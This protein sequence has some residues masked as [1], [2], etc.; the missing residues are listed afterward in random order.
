MT[1]HP[2]QFTESQREQIAQLENFLRD[3]IIDE[4]DYESE[5]SK[6]KRG[7]NVG[8][9]TPRTPG[10]SD[11][12]HLLS[13]T[14]NKRNS[15]TPRHLHELS[16][17]TDFTTMSEEALLL[18][19]RDKK[20]TSTHRLSL[21]RGAVDDEQQQ[22]DE[23]DLEELMY[24]LMEYKQQ[25][26]ELNE[27]TKNLADQVANLKKENA[28]LKKKSSPSPS[29]STVKTNGN[30]DQQTV[31]KL[32]AVKLQLEK[33]QQQAEEELK[34]LNDKLKMSEMDYEERLKNKDR[35]LEKL[36][37]E[38]A[39]LKNNQITSDHHAPSQPLLGQGTAAKSSSFNCTIL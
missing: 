19:G 20:K 29:T 5:L 7:L 8:D 39:D 30:V 3:G 4:T 36:K 1:D 10:R 16:M 32:E 17:A 9:Q 14:D 25:V 27:K 15:T 11:S 2:E 26:A 23:E 22:M 21:N 31:Q 24:T 12:S 38:L 34:K 33:K 18:E 6:V 13:S 35:E 37:M 28:T